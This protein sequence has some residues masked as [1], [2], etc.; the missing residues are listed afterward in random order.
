MDSRIQM[1]RVSPGES[2]HV[3]TPEQMRMRELA[4]LRRPRIRVHRRTDVVIPLWLAIV[5]VAIGIAFE[6]LRS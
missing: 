1:F 4:A 6:V 3:E 2:I 5:V